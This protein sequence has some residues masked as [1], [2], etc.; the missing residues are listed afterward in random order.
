M[1]GSG[2]DV[3]NVSDIKNFWRALG[4]HPRYFPKSAEAIENVDD[5]EIPFL[6]VRKRNEMLELQARLTS[7]F[8]R[9]LWGW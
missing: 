8:V 1:R 9:V 4:V 2:G 6:G 7:L 3:L 5:T